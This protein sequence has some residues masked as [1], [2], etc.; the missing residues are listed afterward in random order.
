MA[1]ELRHDGNEHGGHH[2]TN[3]NELRARQRG[4]DL[5]DQ[6]VVGNEQRHGQTH[7]QNTA[8]IFSVH[9]ARPF[10]S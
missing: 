4:T 9:A 8:A 2:A 1:Q 3:K 6:C 5:F 10:L 7:G